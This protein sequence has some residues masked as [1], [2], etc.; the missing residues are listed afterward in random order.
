MKKNP[1]TILLVDDSSFIHKVIKEFLPDHYSY[2]SAKD[3][4]TAL[5][6]LKEKTFDIILTDVNMPGMSGIELCSVLK[7]GE[8]KSIPIILMSSESNSNTVSKGLEAGANDYLIKPFNKEELITRLQTQFQLIETLREKED[9]AK[10]EA[11]QALIVTMS[12]EINNPLLIAMMKT[13]NLL[14]N[15]K[16][17]F[18]MCEDSKLELIKIENEL[19]RIKEVMIKIRS[20]E[21]LETSVYA[22]QTTMLN[23]EKSSIKKS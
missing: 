5:E 7:A 11:T 21:K 18:K 10:T 14:K 12:H 22:D 6:M 1:H 4:N 19:E 15:K 2:F 20:I 17:K 23:L 13:S 9:L 16:N 3:A 8:Y